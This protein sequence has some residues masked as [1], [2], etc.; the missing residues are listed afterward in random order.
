[1]VLISLFVGFIGTIWLAKKLISDTQFSFGHIALNTEMSKK[2]GYISQ[3]ATL[4]QYVGKTAK[5]VT[6][7]RPGGRIEVEGEIL[8]AVAESGYIERGEEVTILAFENSQFTV[9]KS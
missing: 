2:E 8:D 4:F 5:T 9:S 7:L 3:D 1:M 6:I